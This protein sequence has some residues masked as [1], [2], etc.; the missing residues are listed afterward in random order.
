MCSYGIQVLYKIVTVRYKNIFLNSFV[1]WDL[2]RVRSPTCDFMYNIWRSGGNRTR[3]GFYGV[4]YNTNEL[5]T[6]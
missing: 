2:R 1:P 4:L 3:D 5:H 6:S